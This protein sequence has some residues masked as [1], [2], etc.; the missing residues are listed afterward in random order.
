MGNSMRTRLAEKRHY[1]F[2]GVA[3]SVSGA[4]DLLTPIH[5]RFRQ[6]SMA[7][8]EGTDLSF[9]FCFVPDEKGHV[10]ERP[11]GRAR[12]VYEPP[13]G[14]V[15]YLED[16]HLYINYGDRIRALCDPAHGLTRMSIVESDAANAWLA[17]N[18]LFTLPLVESLKRRELYGLHAAGL[19]VDGKGV[20]LPGAS[21]AGKSTL[22]VALL[23]AGFDFLTDDTIFLTRRGGAGLRMLAF[24]DEIDVTEET[25]RHFPE[26]KV[27][28]DMPK[29]A[30]SRKRQLCA[31]EVYGANITWEC[32]PHALIFPRIAKAEKSVIKPM[33]SGEALLE[34]APN[35]LPT[36]R[37]SSQHHLD[38]LAELAR[39]TDCYRLEAGRDFDAIPKL[40]R[41]RLK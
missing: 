26:L 40:I 18:P 24:P 13:M 21:G 38:V 22:T 20:L 9:E 33:G 12:P 2:H 29:R 34:L 3:I 39:D 23:R 10:I 8:Q 25:A 28:L 6:F 15:L 4:A 37:R 32:R 31:Q 19:S 17:A 30:G 27:L 36:D 5:S 14:K 16:D 41:D 1:I 7:A 11:A 35:V